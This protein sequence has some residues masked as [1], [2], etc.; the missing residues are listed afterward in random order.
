MALSSP[1]KSRPQGGGLARFFRFLFL[2]VF[3]VGVV[4][5]VWARGV[6]TRA[7]AVESVDPSVDRPGDVALIDGA[8]IHF[9][10][11]G[12]SGQVLL[13]VH[14]YDVFAG[15]EWLPLA[16]AMQT[17]QL[18]MPDQVGFGYSTRPTE[19]GLPLTV[20]GR[21]ETLHLLMQ[22]L[23]LPATVVIGSGGGVAIATQLAALHPDDVTGL[24]LISGSAVRSRPS[25]IERAMGWPVVGEA[26]AYTF[27]AGG[28][29]SARAFAAGCDDGGWCPTSEQVDERRHV[30]SVRG[31][32]AGLALWAS[33]PPA[34]TLPS[35]LDQI[36][37]PTLVLWGE[38]DQTMSFDD[39]QE[40]A[41][42]I[43][44]SELRVV[45]G[46]G[47]QPHLEDPAAV[48]ALI[49]EFLAKLD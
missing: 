22:A 33:T 6:A 11:E 9:R 2:L 45:V 14:D 21:A 31:T 37:V 47:H 18:L 25:L 28:E 48:A 15:A 24:V 40:M 17:G 42:S 19:S 1:P 27:E 8:T 23:D 16:D 35:D 30:A 10:R 5:A 34:S 49:T 39:A 29:R 12:G 43:A 13:L 4:A 38:D 32:S 41:A 46:A 26:V 3:V 36:A 20:A 44:G 7:E